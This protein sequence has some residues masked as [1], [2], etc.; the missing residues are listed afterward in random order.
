[1]SIPSFLQRAALAIATSLLLALPLHASER[2][3]DSAYG[4]L[5]LSGP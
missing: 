1:M 2:T 4:P 5:K 3:L